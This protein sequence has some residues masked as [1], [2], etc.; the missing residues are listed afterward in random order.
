MDVMTDVSVSDHHR[1][2]LVR[3]GNPVQTNT[4]RII[5]V[6]Y[7]LVLLTLTHLPPSNSIRIS[8]MWTGALAH[9][10]LFTLLGLLGAWAI[11]LRNMTRGFV[12]GLG[13]AAFAAMDECT[14]SWTG[15]TPDYADWLADAVGVTLGIALYF[16]ARTMQSQRR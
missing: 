13:L 9:V 11:P 2:R 15:R 6:A 5:W 7:W 12:L 14:Q 10:L 8:G 3:G 1:R 16:L 4:R